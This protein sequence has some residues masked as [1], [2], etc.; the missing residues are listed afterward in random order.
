MYSNELTKFDFRYFYR[1]GK[2]DLVVVIDDVE[3]IY[4]SYDDIERCKEVELFL[5][6]NEEWIEV[7]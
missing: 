4:G 5:L 7:I 2:W 1:N 3:I 6:E